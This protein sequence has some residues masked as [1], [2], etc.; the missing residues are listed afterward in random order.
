MKNIQLQQFLT[1]LT[2]L[3]L[4]KL[5]AH[6]EVS[7]LDIFTVLLLAAIVEH[8]FIYLKNGSIDFF[9]FSALST[10]LGLLLMM[11]VTSVWIY[12]VAII[13]ALAQKYLIKV[14]NHHIFNPSN[15]ALVVTMILFY[16]KAHITAGQLGDQYWLSV[17][18]LLLGGIVLY[19]ANRLLI[20]LLFVIFYILFQD[21]FVVGYDPILLSEDIY[22]R[23]YQVSYIV[24]ILFMITDP[25]TTPSKLIYQMLFV[26]LI[27]LIDA[28]LDRYFGYRVIHIFISLFVV[29]PVVP[30]V[31]YK[32]KKG[33]I[34]LLISI[35]LIAVSLS[36]YLENMPPYYFGVD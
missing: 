24:F 35:W 8:T 10:A 23:F 7:Y 29:S 25:R 22:Q 6:I 13:I 17:I 32:P 30:L 26:V 2:L 11:S 12:A 3:I 36:I 9:S 1:L 4:G 15:F 21:I 16:D 5:F 27:T 20:S 34:Y 33:D 14:A 19:R 28:M 31:C 18:V